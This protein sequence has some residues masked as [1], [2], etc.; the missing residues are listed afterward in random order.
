M[1][2]K[3]ENPLG[4]EPVGKLLRKF[5]VPSIISMLVMSLYNI[6]DQIFIGQCV[7]EL[8]NAATNVAF[9]FTTLCIATALAFGIGGASGFNLNLGAGEK[10]KAPYFIGVS[11]S[12]MFIIGV[13]LSVVGL[14]ALKPLLLFFGSTDT[15]LPYAMEYTKYLALGFPFAII[16]SGGSHLVRADGSPKFSMA[17]NLVG[18][19]VN[20][21]LDYLF[22][23]VFNWKMA[24]A[25]IATVIGQ[26]LASIMVIWYLIHFKTIKLH[27]K[28]FVPQLKIVGRTVHLGM[29]QCLNQLAIMFVQVVMNKSLTYYGALSPYGADIPLACT[30][31]VMKVNQVY[32]SICIGVAQGIQPIASF[33][34]GAG[35]N[36]R[37]K[38]TYKLAVSCNTIISTIAFI[39]FQLFP[40]QI[41]SI[42]GS[43]SPEY[44]RF[45]INFFRIFLFMTFLDGIQPITSTFCTVIGEPN[46]GTF[47]SLTRQV[48]C[49]IPLMIVLPYIFHNFGYLGIDGMMYVAPISDF[50][51]AVLSLI[52][53]KKVFKKLV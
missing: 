8:G 30:G 19:I 20:V 5:A 37:V 11:A 18:A 4:T 45:S 41:I 15:V 46:K 12:M 1:N 51:A 33:N 29:A 49:F 50:L 17:C 34:R 14:T 39:I 52:V 13:V 32:F 36:D 24:G 26:I 43:G 27:G 16:S 22:V 3:I 6:V 44:F 35:K 21:I 10:E 47:L 40:R 38:K 28:H 53:I 23:M 2:E 25:A 31:I 9:P 42:F 48:I 7:G